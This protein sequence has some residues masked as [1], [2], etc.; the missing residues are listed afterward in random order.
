[1]WYIPLLEHLPALHAL[2]Y[3]RDSL[4]TDGVEVED[5]H[6]SHRETFPR[7]QSVGRAECERYS[8]RQVV[9]GHL[10]CQEAVGVHWGREEHERRIRVS[11]YEHTLRG[12]DIQ[13]D[14]TEVPWHDRSLAYSQKANHV[15]VDSRTYKNEGQHIEEATQL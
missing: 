5:V 3:A 6:A 8:A 7:V 4:L 2:L 15:S 9:P 13:P 1:M 14:V 11:K 10:H 12:K